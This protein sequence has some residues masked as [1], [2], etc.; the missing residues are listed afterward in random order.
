MLQGS[1]FQAQAQ[2]LLQHFFQPLAKIPLSI[3][4]GV[5]G[6]SPPGPPILGKKVPR[7]VYPRIEGLPPGWYS[8][9]IHTNS[10]HTRSLAEST[11]EL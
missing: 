10:I 2:A 9:L 7:T 4:S 1:V 8:D 6:Y 3:K 5:A 11:T